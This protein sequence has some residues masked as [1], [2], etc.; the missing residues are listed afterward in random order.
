M[1]VIVF[2]IQNSFSQYSSEILLYFTPLT[3]S[4]YASYSTLL[5]APCPAVV[6][7]SEQDEADL[8]VATCG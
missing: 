4:R 6:L 1:L 7:S 3:F 8:P 5:E 2:R